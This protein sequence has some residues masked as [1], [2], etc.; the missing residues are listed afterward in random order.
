MSRERY[1]AAIV[2]A[3]VAIGIALALVP[4]SLTLPLA[5]GAAVIAMTIERLAF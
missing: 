2:G 1:A 5:L 4:G 3:L